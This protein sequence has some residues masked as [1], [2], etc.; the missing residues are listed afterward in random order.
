MRGPTASRLATSMS[1]TRSV[2]RMDSDTMTKVWTTSVRRIRK[3]TSAT[4]RDLPQ[5]RK[6]SARVCG[7]SRALEGVVLSPASD[8]PRAIHDEAGTGGER[9]G[10]TEADS[11]RAPVDLALGHAA[12]LEA[13]Q[14][15]F[16]APQV[17]TP[18]LEAHEEVRLRF[19]ELTQ[20]VL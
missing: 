14:L 5:S 19:V 4:R 2:S 20:L 18:L 13:V 15:V 11:L 12:V 1:P 10:S 6:L 9:Q 7:S 17:V 3:R 16:H 8:G